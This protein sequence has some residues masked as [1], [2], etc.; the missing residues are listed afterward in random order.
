MVSSFL[1]LRRVG[2]QIPSIGAFAHP[3]LPFSPLPN[4]PNPRIILKRKK[5]VSNLP[6][7]LLDDLT[8]KGSSLA[9]VAL[10]AGDT[11]LD[12][13]GSGFLLIGKISSQRPSSAKSYV[14]IIVVFFRDRGAEILQEVRL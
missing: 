1:S 13:T 6:S 3:A 10:G 4:P 11:G 9:E 14:R 8:N 12:N 7:N 2:N 5:E